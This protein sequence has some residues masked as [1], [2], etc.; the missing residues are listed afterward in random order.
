M[1]R[2]LFFLYIHDIIVGDLKID[3]LQRSGLT[4]SFIYFEQVRS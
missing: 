4:K 3:M 1:L 2:K